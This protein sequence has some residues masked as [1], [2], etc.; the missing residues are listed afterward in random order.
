MQETRN[1]CDG[2]CLDI[3]PKYCYQ[4][5][6]CL[7]EDR[8]SNTSQITKQIHKFLPH[9]LGKRKIMTKQF[10]EIK[11]QNIKWKTKFQFLNYTF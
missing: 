3:S 6:H 1:F 8:A 4:L 10:W 11:G 9:L 5:W 2:I 7:I